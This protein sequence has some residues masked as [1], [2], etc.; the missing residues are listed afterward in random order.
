M[1]DFDIH[2]P[3]FAAC[4]FEAYREL[5]GNDPV[6][7]SDKY[8]GFHLL[9]RYADVRAAALDWRRYT[10][11]VVGVTAIPVITPR[12]KPQLPIEVDPPLHSTYRALVNPTFGP[13]R[14]AALKPSVEALARKL[15]ARMIETG[16]AEAVRDYC[17]PLA[18]GTLGVF[19]GLPTEDAA[20]WE[21]WL[22]A[23]FDPRRPEAGRAAA[24]AFGAYIRD[25]I[26]KRQTRP[27]DDF[28]SL[29][30]GAEIE[31]RKLTEDEVHSF[32]T[33]M[34]G[35]GFETTADA[36][37]GALHWLA[38]SPDRLGW[39]RDHPGQTA[40]AAEEF[41]RFVSPVQIFGRNA[42]EDIS[43]HGVTIP[44]G[45]IVAL[46]F[47]AAN[48][49]P[50]AFDNPEECILARSPNR[51]LAFGAGPHLCLGAPVARLEMAVT[52]TLLRQAVSALAPSA[53][54]AV[55]KTRGDR[56]G[57]SKLPLRISGDVAVLAPDA[58][59]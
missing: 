10:S 17:M 16:E 22:D 2:D 56:R 9:T 40:Q 58:G 30:L 44:N 57:L 38:L 49:D 1:D 3:K 13:T 32:V 12:T 31:G 6:H 39:L 41:F 51:H 25:L 26:A 54:D 29:L 59:G 48:R 15:L 24:D 43:L 21:V 35:A 11:S 34:F 33:V 27:A 46:G 45:R 5:R 14:I 8:G 28:V 23:M 47:G 18:I 50:A 19:T 37:S 20:S 7:A 55:W 36:M 42:T 4:P 52:L 53:E